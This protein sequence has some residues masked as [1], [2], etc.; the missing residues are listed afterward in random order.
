MPDAENRDR[1]P[2]TAQDTMAR[3]AVGDVEMADAEG[4]GGDVEAGR[5]T[6]AQDAVA[7]VEMA[8]AGAEG[9]PFATEHELEPLCGVPLA[10]V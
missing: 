3:E 6:M 4:Q 2:E 7:N 10:S 5:I 8:D 9:G 1:N